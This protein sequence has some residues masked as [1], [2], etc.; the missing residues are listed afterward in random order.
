MA[1]SRD[2]QLLELVVRENIGIESCLTSNYQTHTVDD[3]RCHPLP[4]FLEA[5]ARVC[6]NTDDPAVENTSLPQEYALASQC[7]GLAGSQLEQLKRHA[8]EMAFLSFQEKQQLLQE[9]S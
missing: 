8:I 6:L 4:L 5:G 9:T 7:L 1:I 2:P 3:L